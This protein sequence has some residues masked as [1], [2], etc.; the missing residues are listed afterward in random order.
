[1][2]LPVE[3]VMSLSP[4]R[5]LILFCSYDRFQH[6]KNIQYGERVLNLAGI[7]F[8]T[9]TNLPA[10]REWYNAISFK[11]AT[12]DSA[13]FSIEGLPD[14]LQIADYK[15][16][17]DS[18]YLGLALMEDKGVGLWVVN[19]KTRKAKRIFEGYLSFSL[20]GEEMFAW[21]P[22]EEALVFTAVP[23]R[24][25]REPDP[26]ESKPTV[27][28]N[29]HNVL[30]Q[31]TYQ[32]LLKSEADEMFFEYYATAQLK[33]VSLKGKVS[34]L[35]QKG[36]IA[37]FAPS[38]DG[39]YIKVHYVKK[40]YSYAL[41]VH[42]FP[43]DVVILGK[44]GIE[45]TTIEVP[46]V[47][48][49]L[50]R[51]AAYNVPRSFAWRTDVGATLT[52]VQ[53]KDGGDPKVE[54]KERDL[55]YS[56]QAPFDKAPV[57]L[58]K[59][60][61]RLD[62]VHWLNDTLAILVEK[63]WAKRTT[64]WLLFNPAT[65]Q[66][67]DT[68]AQFN[69][70][71][72]AFDQGSLISIRDRGFKR[73]FFQDGSVYLSRKTLNG[74]KEVV[75]VLEK[76][77]ITTKHR[78]E[79]WRS[80]AP[81]YEYVV[82]IDVKE[83]GDSFIVARQSKTVPV[84]LVRQYLKTGREGILTYN[85]NNLALL[86]RSLVKKELTYLRSDSVTLQATLYYN[87]DSLRADRPMRCLMYAYPMDYISSA[88]AG[89]VYTY[90]YMFESSFSLQK[91]LALSGYA[92]MD[93]VSF[94]I[95]GMNGSSPNDTYLE[96]IELN[97]QAAVAAAKG[98]G[99]VDVDNI[100]VMGHSYGAF[101][102]ANLLTHTKLFKTGIAMSGAYNRSLTP[103]GFQREYRTYWEEQALYHRLSPFQNAHRLERPILLF[104]GE[105]DEN[106]GTHYRQTE[107][108]FAAL[109][110]LGKTAR[111]VSLPDEA[112]AYTLLASYLHIL[113]EVDRWLNKHL[114]QGPV[115]RAATLNDGM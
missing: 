86:N 30:P 35:G 19:V 18:Q 93:N 87:K 27:Y 110:G 63:W 22:G 37:D 39:N 16:S 11:Y 70:Q 5:K 66:L 69:A 23:P 75:P 99:I 91:L 65:S 73:L 101:M 12:E 51:D 105:T 77:N 109:K 94:P 21:L 34:D 107:Q 106:P 92:V 57:V 49:P 50:G 7:Q 17:F 95:I 111:F 72:T 36:I 84:N 26:G 38:P 24:S 47:I 6:R 32:G 48:R 61:L 33:K 102:V 2:K 90:P 31:R 98:T 82:A 96:Q 85:K 56:W 68:L 43:S 114:K 81:F 103:F 41:T 79:L 83:S 67:L 9:G 25:Q 80:R 76:L 40:P 10:D 20:V 4:D 54:Q 71:S 45:V 115:L 100:A 28:E 78:Q 15:W 13:T 112:H 59:T 53:A 52:W 62:D 88:S 29:E 46:P 55:L 42:R 1:M 108:Y 64:N 8:N 104:H 3:P 44:D 113:W 58:Q 14:T 74:K 97:A 89:K 60:S